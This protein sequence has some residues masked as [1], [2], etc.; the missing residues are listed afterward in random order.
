MTLAETH[1][2]MCVQGAGRQAA[3][4]PVLQSLSI[5][6]AL[7]GP[8]LDVLV[9]QQF[10]NAGRDDVEAV[11]TFPLPAGA[12]LAGLEFDLRGM[13]FQGTV[14]GK[15]EAARQY[16]DA[17]A[18]GDTPVLVQ[19]T[20][21]GLFTAQLGNLKP[22]ECAGIRLRY[23]QCLAADG[24][25]WRIAIPTVLAPL[26]GDPER[27]AGLAPHETPRNSMLAQYPLGFEFVAH[28][29]HDAAALS[30]SSHAVDIADTPAGVRLVARA[31]AQLDRDIVIRVLRSQPILAIA[32]PDLPRTGAAPHVALAALRLPAGPIEGRSAAAAPPMVRPLSLRIVLDCSGSMAGDSIDWAAVACQRLLQGLRGEDEFSITLFGSSQVHWQDR[33]VGADRAHV[34]AAV[35]WLYGVKA[36]LGGT[37]MLAALRSA[38]ALPGEHRD[39]DM[40]LITDGQIWGTDALVREARG[41]GRRVFL[42]GVGSSPRDAFLRELAEATG[43]RCQV[44]APGEALTRAVDP[45]VER[46]RAPVVD[47]IAVHWP[48]RPTWTVRWPQRPLPGETVF[49]YAGFDTPCAGQVEIVIG[50]GAGAYRAVAAI[51]PALLAGA[52]LRSV[53]ASERIRSG[54]FVDAAQAAVD[55]QLVTEWT[56]LVAVAHR[57]ADDKA[58]SMPQL[59]KVEQMVPAGWGGTG[60]LTQWLHRGAPALEGSMPAPVEAFAAGMPSF[61]LCATP[62]RTRSGSAPTP[63][64]PARQRA[65]QRK[66][67]VASRRDEFRDAFVRLQRRRFG[68]AVAGQP[69]LGGIALL[70]WAGMPEALL[71]ELVAGGAQAVDGAVLVERFVALY[72]PILCGKADLQS[73]DADPSA[74]GK[75]LARALLAFLDRDAPDPLAL[76]RRSS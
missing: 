38:A 10:K 34:A 52:P 66:Q 53:A 49:L 47:S 25:A 23:A 1:A 4:A 63:Q 43:G 70:R 13:R 31:G 7:Q 12:V 24:D 3:P 8:L 55:Y 68:Q 40:L 45:V 67:V 11:Y 28:D 22:G 16:E 75:L 35:E 50:D 14:K 27:E 54:H 62:S 74:I 72:E 20:A 56:A 42:V 30:C 6:A 9:E 64:D 51:A 33:L 29:V 65:T 15:Q 58:G 69:E 41:A 39:S 76:L 71:D 73:L 21:V 18:E 59:A 17:I 44:V 57:A 32:A 2:S 37:E 5:R 46:L 60:K 48:A 36:N 26:Y 61:F 19:R